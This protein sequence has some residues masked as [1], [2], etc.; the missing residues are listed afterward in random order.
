MN[1]QEHRY[2]A[3]IRWTGNLGSG[4]S[5]Y[6]AYSRD[7]EIDVDGPGTLP[8]TADPTFHGSR[9]RWNPEQLLLTAVAQ[10]HMLS[11]LHVAV[12]SGVVVTG[13]RDTAV[14]TMHLNRDGSGEFTGITLEPHV[15]LADAGQS[16]LADALHAEANRLCF[17]ARSVNFPVHHAPTSGPADQ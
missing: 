3:R 12:R 1:L 11:Y 17:I 2:S 9:D 8:G 14:G 13:Y 7:H 6:R 4:T 5:G 10:C 15:E 16:A